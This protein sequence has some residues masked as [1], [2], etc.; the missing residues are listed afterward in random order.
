MSEIRIDADLVL[1]EKAVSAP[2]EDEVVIEGYFATYDLD[3]QN[4][5]FLPGS[6]SEAAKSFMTGGSRAVLFQHK[7]ELGQL[8]QVEALEERKGGLWGRA[9]LP[10]PAESSPLYDHWLKIKSGMM[11][12]ISIRSRML[13]KRLRDGSRVCIPTDIAEF[14]MTPTPV[15]MGG[16]IALASKALSDEDFTPDP[17]PDEDAAIRTYL[18]EKLTAANNTLD[19]LESQLPVVLDAQ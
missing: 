4:E 8:G 7:P 14:S 18:N 6:F 12:G 9:R 19:E 17:E 2:S 10:R 13:A 3:R 1:G 15:N 16:V 5:R 11:K